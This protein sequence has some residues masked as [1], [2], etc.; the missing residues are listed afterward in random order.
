MTGWLAGHWWLAYLAIGCV[1]GFAAGLLGIG[2]GIVMVPMLVFA[3][4][5]QD[6]SGAHVL[7]LALGTSMA[8]IAFTSLSSVRAH[9]KLGSVD[10][11]I[12]L[13]LSP[14]IMAGSFTAALVAGLIATRPLAILFTVL[15]FYAATQMFFDLR[16]KTTRALP[17]K[18]GLFL[19]GAIIGGVASLLSAGGAFLSIPFLAWC[20]VPLRRAIGTAAAI[21]FPIALAGTAGYVLQGL[22]APDLP[23]GSLGFVYAPALAM[24]V[25]TSVLV[26]PLGA[27]LAHRLPVK[28]LRVAFALFLYAMAI[29]MLL[30]IG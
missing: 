23:P 8:T 18:A 11:P 19:S 5:A 30:S 20:G 13:T 14:G 22:R 26:A 17:G 25:A 15:M 4:G 21:G 10:W 27:R 29:R 24:L 2:G 12:A 16:P 1:V 6:F 9:H 3:F 28:R 7:H